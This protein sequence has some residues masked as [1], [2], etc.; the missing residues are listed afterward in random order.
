MIYFP[1]PNQHPALCNTINI[2]RSPRRS[3]ADHAF[4]LLCIFSPHLLAQQG[5][6]R[7]PQGEGALVGGI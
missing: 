4:M 3:F 7:A 6:R 5:L 2:G 1:N